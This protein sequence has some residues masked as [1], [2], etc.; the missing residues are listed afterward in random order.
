VS[1]FLWLVGASLLREFQSSIG[2]PLS[3]AGLLAVWTGVLLA[4]NIVVA[5]WAAR[6][7]NARSAT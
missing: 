1:V 3:F 6:R 7:R 2:G 5:T 4:A